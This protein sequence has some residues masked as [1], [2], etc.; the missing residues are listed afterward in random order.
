MHR[1]RRDA[2]GIFLPSNST[3]EISSNQGLDIN[4]FAKVFV[5][6]RN[7]GVYD[8]V[9]GDLNLLNKPPEQNILPLVPYQP[10]M[11]ALGGGGPPP[12][13]TFEFPIPE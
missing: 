2:L 11:V 7:Q 1:R 9:E 3:L 12:D 5:E 4:P 8:L 13:P 10:K 6:A